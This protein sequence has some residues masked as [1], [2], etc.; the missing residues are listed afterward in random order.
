[1]NEIIQTSGPNGQVLHPSYSNTGII[2]NTYSSHLNISSPDVGIRLSTS[3][4]VVHYSCHS[5][6]A[7]IDQSN[8]SLI[9]FLFDN[10]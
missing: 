4:S 8:K 10:F 1:M 3:F 5:T 2:T 9:F 7:H 6:A